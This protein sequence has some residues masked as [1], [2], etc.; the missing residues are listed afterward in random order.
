MFNISLLCPTLQRP[1]GL[2]RVWVSALNTANN[3][4]E[5]ELIIYAESYDESTLSKATELQNKFGNQV[6]TI[7]ASEKLPYGNLHNICCKEA[8]SDIF[9][10]TTDDLI[11]RTHDW[12]LRIKETFD[13]YDDKIMYVYPNDG[14]WGK[15]LG[16]H[17]FVHRRWYEALGYIHPPIFTA[18]YY[19]NY[20]MDVCR[21]LGRDMYV[22]E[23]LIEHMHW[24]FGKSDFDKTAQEVHQRRTST[25]NSVIYGSQSTHDVQSQDIAKLQQAIDNFKKKEKDSDG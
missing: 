12:D 5:I 14:H 4:E 18:D 9:M 17:G 8:R 22:E 7:V 1:L 2:E 16:T 24:T 6:R 13:K 25:D 10:C 3:P 21:A 23:V 15:Q 11:F 20:L 19:D